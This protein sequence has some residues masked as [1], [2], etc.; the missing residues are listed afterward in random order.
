M[1]ARGREAA[2]TDELVA[3]RD[4]HVAAHRLARLLAVGGVAHD[5][6]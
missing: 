2:R 6:D 4:E 1:R 3:A 5:R